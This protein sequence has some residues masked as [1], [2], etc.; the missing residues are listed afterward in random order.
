MKHYIAALFLTLFAMA[1]AGTLVACATMLNQQTTTAAQI[2]AVAEQ[3]SVQFLVIAEVQKIGKEDPAKAKALADRA[4]ATIK[5]INAV[6]N[7][8]TTSTL[9]FNALH[10]QV[11]KIIADQHYD[12]A[13]LVAVETVRNMVDLNFQDLQHNVAI[14]PGNLTPK[15]IDGLK[16]MLSK[17]DD[18]LIL[19]GY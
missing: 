3:G 12:A 4:H 1:I 6:L 11:S 5:T 2:R 14:T 13:T 18:A 17:I 10:D 7:G 9:D 16:V 19:A 8:S 15:E